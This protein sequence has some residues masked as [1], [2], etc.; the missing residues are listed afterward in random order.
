[1]Y[2]IIALSLSLFLSFSLA[3]T[4]S[5]HLIRLR[6]ANE[7]VQWT[8]GVI[9][10]CKTRRKKY[11]FFLRFS[12]LSIDVQEVQMM[13]III[14]CWWHVLNKNESAFMYINIYIYIYLYLFFRYLRHSTYAMF[15]WST[16]RSDAFILYVY[17]C[18][19]TE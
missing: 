14:C 15:V 11:V 16:P 8:M 5:F 4:R 9:M 19:S 13:I 12:F 2:V 10:N 7:D 17:R 3:Y 1:M 6:H 18:C